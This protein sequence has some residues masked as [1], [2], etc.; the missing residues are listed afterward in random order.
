MP[1]SPK[2]PVERGRQVVRHVSVGELAEGL[3]PRHGELAR[4]AEAGDRLAYLLHPG[5]PDPAAAHLDHER[6]DPVVVVRAPQALDDVGQPDLAPGHD[7]GHRIGDRPLTDAVGQVEFE[8]QRP[9][10]ALP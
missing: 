3:G 7:R 9:V 10:L 2:V 6:P 8:D 1:V 5:Q 4:L